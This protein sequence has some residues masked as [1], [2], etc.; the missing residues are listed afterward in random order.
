MLPLQPLVVSVPLPLATG[1]PPQQKLKSPVWALTSTTLPG[2]LSSCRQK[3]N[4]VTVKLQVA[5]F[6]ATSVAV[7]VTVVVPTGKTEPELGLQATVTPGQLSDAVT[8]KFIGPVLVAMGQEAASVVVIFEGQVTVGGCVSTTVT[9]NEH[10]S[11][12]APPFDLHVT[13][14]VP[15]GKNEPEAGEQLTV[16]QAPPLVVGE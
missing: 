10:I 13:V 5:V 3:L 11:G 14:V 8:V 6:P 2:L 1:T 16:P 15:T 9:V 7:Q 12:P 4:A